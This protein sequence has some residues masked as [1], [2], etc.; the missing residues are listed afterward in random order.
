MKLSAIAGRGSRKDFIDLFA[1]CQK[2]EPLE[3]LFVHFEQKFQDVRYDRYH[4]LR[5]LTFFEDAEE[6]ALPEML[7][8]V[9][10]EEVRQFFREEVRRLFR[11]QEP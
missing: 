3:Q 10:W 1:I 2:V 5:S 6:E 7:Y 8:S 9:R 4:L 11:P